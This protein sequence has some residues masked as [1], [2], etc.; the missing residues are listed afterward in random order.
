MLLESS[1]D[2]KGLTSAMTTGTWASSI[3]HP[4]YDQPSIKR[5]HEITDDTPLPY[6]RRR[7]STLEH[8]F[9]HLTLENPQLITKVHPQP[10]N[11]SIPLDQQHPMDTNFDLSSS[12][13]LRPS[14]I[15]EPT[16][17]P[18]IKMKNTSWYEPE[19]DRIVITDLDDSDEEPESDLDLTISSVLL[20]HIKTRPVALEAL[21][22]QVAS[23]DTSKALVLFKPV[24]VAEKDARVEESERSTASLPIK[25]DY[26][27]DVEP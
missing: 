20:D 7:C 27:M 17:I 5:K 9:A 12:S 26:A 15:E 3:R 14:S 24:K 13:V 10:S 23:K 16:T 25:D 4:W 11:P 1:K 6:K 22:R 18:E 21:A 8:G 19:K 2:V